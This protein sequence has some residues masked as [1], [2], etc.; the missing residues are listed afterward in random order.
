VVSVGDGGVWCRWER[1]RESVV[2][3]SERGWVHVRGVYSN[4]WSHIGQVP[5]ITFRSVNIVRALD[6]SISAWSAGNA[7]AGPCAN[8]RRAQWRMD[9]YVGECALCCGS[10]LYA[11]RYLIHT[12]TC[13][14]W[15]FFTASALDAPLGAE[16][17]IH[18]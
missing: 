8:I 2:G 11:V 7:N 12:C 15:H 3:D 14:I 17:G 9:T 18:Q 6:H 13:A 4:V 5:S 10:V 1:E 16:Q